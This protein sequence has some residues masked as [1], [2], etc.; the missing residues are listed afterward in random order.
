MSFLVMGLG[1]SGKAVAEFLGAKN[2]SFQ[3]WDDQK[4][5]RMLAEKKSWEV[6]HPKHLTSSTEVIL[7][8]G[9]AAQ[10][11]LL[12]QAKE[13]GCHAIS[14]IQFFFQNFPNT[15]AIGITGSHGKSTTCALVHHALSQHEIP[16]L[17]A[18]NFGIPVFSTVLHQDVSPETLYILELSSY[19]LEQ[20]HRL[21]LKIGALLNLS[22]H[23]LERHG[24]LDGYAKIKEKIFHHAEIAMVGESY[25]RLSAVLRDHTNT[26]VLKADSAPLP[27]PPH[28]TSPHSVL[29]CAAATT[30]LSALHP[31]PFS[32]QTFKGLP[33]RQEWLPPVRGISYCNDSKSTSP[34]AAA[35]ALEALKHHRIFWIMGG[36]MQDDD[37]SVLIP[38]LPNVVEGFAIGTSALRYRDFLTQHHVPIALCNTLETAVLQATQR[39]MA[40]QPS[41]STILFSPGC[42]SYDAFQNFEH[43]GD[44]FRNIVASLGPVLP[45]LN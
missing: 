10:H 37:L 12:V 14:D 24:S 1:K 33:H 16:C 32:F 9:I 11:P 18:G 44:C 26:V 40:Y 31:G 28:L 36:V 8:P 19:Q 34:T 35:C 30:I 2:V 5:M 7:S 21:P 42:A 23:H 39:A 43:R 41:Q 29:N 4:E 17:M 38:F 3:V 22:P 6:K 45:V 27:L 25:P 15:R 13:K 20:C